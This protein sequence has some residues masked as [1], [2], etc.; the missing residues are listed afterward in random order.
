MRI[1]PLLAVLVGCNEAPIG[2]GT[3]QPPLGA[4]EPEP[5]LVVEPTEL[6]FGV[7]A[8]AC[9]SEPQVVTLRNEGDGELQIHEITLGGAWP[10]MFELQGAPLTLGPGEHLDVPITFLPDDEE[11]YRAQLVVQSNDETQPTARAS[12]KGSGWLYELVEESWTQDDATAVD[13]LWVIDNSGSMSDEV[14]DL[15]DAFQTFIDAF[16]DYELDYHIGVITTDMDDP[17][18]SGRFQGEVITSLTD[19]PEAEFTSQAAQGFDGSADEQGFKASKHALTAPLVNQGHNQDFLRT[20]ARLA[21]VFVSDEDDPP[22]DG[23]T[24]NQFITWVT[25]L[26]TDPT[27][28]TVSGLVGARATGFASVFGSCPDAMAAPQYHRA[29]QQTGGVWGNICNQDL[30]PF[31]N[32]VAQVASGRL[33]EFPLASPPISTGQM[34]VLRNGEPV[35][36]GFGGWSY[37]PVSFTVHL[38]EDLELEPGDEITVRYPVEPTCEEQDPSPQP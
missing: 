10:Q 27:D 32:H 31:L 17:A 16:V 20:D 35:D 4:P 23:I 5:L 26:K 9:G 15:A 30:D 29:I 3:P 25:G 14:G 1:L 21:V 11:D 2:I 28:V 34:E 33:E 38:D 6:D 24:A 36:Y 18:H 8:L 22:L 13:V 37:D 7:V 12:L 19:D